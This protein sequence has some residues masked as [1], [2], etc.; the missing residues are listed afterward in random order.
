MRRSKALAVCTVVLALG[1][2]SCRSGGADDL[3]KV[4]AA[5][6]QTLKATSAKVAITV[7]T[8]V[9]GSGTTLTG[10][11]SYD[12]SARQGLLSLR[13]G[14]LLAGT[15]LD[16][17]I[18]GDTAYV[19]PPPFLAAVVRKP[20]L[21]ID[22]GLLVTESPR[23]GPISSTV[24]PVASV[25]AIR[26]AVDA[27]VVGEETVR[28]VATTH[29]RGRLD[30]AAA[31]DGLDD[32]AGASLRRLA[33]LLGS[34]TVPYDVWL[35][36]DGRVRRTTYEVRGSAAATATASGQPPSGSGTTTVTTELFEF[37]TA[38]QVDVPPLDQVA[39]G[40][41]FLRAVGG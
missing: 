35:D 39:P 13:L 4:R 24:D 2:V 26:G 7:V 19:A 20:F 8:D 40:N 27:E 9:G 15:T 28:G 11:G 5:S 33:A 23:F 31:A 37:G 6:A 21:Q 17:R 34:E 25:D 18:V 1:G 32:A 16:A 29:Y 38:V 12:L 10:E 41:A 3:S 14:S 22:L 30:M 36:A